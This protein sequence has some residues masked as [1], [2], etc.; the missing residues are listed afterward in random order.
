MAPFPD[1]PSERNRPCRLRDATS[2]AVVQRRTGRDS[3]PRGLL[4]PHD[5]QSC[6]LSRSDTC[7]VP[8]RRAFRRCQRRGWDSNPRGPCGPDGLA[9]RCR[10]HL[11]TS[12]NRRARPKTRPIELPLLGS[13]QDSSDPESDVLPVTPR[14]SDDGMQSGRR[15]SNPRPSAWEADALPTELLPRACRSS[16]LPVAEP[17]VR[18]ELTTARLRIECSTSEL[19][20]R[21]AM[22]ATV[23]WS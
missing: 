8:S 13:N 14:G 2:P 10:N 12:P 16:T 18:I 23:K 11:A 15:G 17:P 1:L 6:S 9:N 7:P 20:W 22:V 19:R 21:V 5:F 4:T 3:N